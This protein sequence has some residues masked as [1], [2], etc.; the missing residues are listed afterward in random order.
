MASKTDGENEQ[1]IR[2]LDWHTR[3]TKVQI[4]PWDSLDVI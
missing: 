1:Q 4:M 3:L 2:T